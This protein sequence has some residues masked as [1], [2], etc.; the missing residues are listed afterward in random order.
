MK[1]PRNNGI[2]ADGVAQTEADHFDKCPA[3]RHWFDMRD[4]GEVLAHVHDADIE[5]I[6]GPA[7]PRAGILQ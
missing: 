3:C 7:P 4:L 2:D 1:V 6:E 5:I